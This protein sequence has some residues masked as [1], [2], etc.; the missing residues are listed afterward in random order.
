MLAYKL[1]ANADGTID[2][3]S[4][5]RAAGLTRDRFA[6]LLYPLQPGPV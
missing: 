5:L 3:S 1:K 4:A 6:Y 2:L